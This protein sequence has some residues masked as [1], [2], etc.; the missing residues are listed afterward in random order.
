MKNS[1]IAVLIALV[2]TA[3]AL[4]DKNY[5]ELG[6]GYVG[7]TFQLDHLETPEQFSFAVGKAERDSRQELAFTYTDTD[8]NGFE[9]YS[10]MVN[11]Y[12]YL[13]PE[14]ELTRLYVGAGAG[15]KY[16]DTSDD[17]D[18]V[19]AY[20]L[21]AGAETRVADNVVFTYGYQLSDADFGDTNVEHTFKVGV[22]FEF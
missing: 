4:A 15:I 16:F 7:S 1:L 20:Q 21:T 18:L 17:S 5:I 14:T 3:P 6:T 22:R 9:T 13:T 19:F 2:F 8:V 11:G 10:V 12:F